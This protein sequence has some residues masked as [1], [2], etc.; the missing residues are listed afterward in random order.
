MRV[1]HSG[2]AIA[3][4]A[5]FSP[6]ELA[7][8]T[9]TPPFTTPIGVFFAPLLESVGSARP[10]AN[11]VSALSDRL[12]GTAPDTE[13]HTHFYDS[14]YVCQA[15]CPIAFSL[16]CSQTLVVFLRRWLLTHA[17]PICRR[18]RSTAWIWRYLCTCSR[19]GRSRL[20]VSTMKSTVELFT[21]L[22]LRSVS[23]R[24]PHISRH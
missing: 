12:Q 6:F 3:D 15:S 17:P 19:S 9:F 8:P 1:H 2:D 5:A 18:R 13:S 24:A 10:R 7:F 23:K 22:R 20:N 21:P 14:D 16:E 11:E 4:F